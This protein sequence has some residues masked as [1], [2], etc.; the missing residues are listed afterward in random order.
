ML[1]VALLAMVLCSCWGGGEKVEP[2]NMG[3]LA[4]IDIGMTKDEV[5]SAI[6]E[7]H[8]EWKSGTKRD[9][10]YLYALPKLGERHPNCFTLLYADDVLTQIAIADSKG[11]LFYR[12]LQ[13]AGE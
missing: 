10:Y 9:A 12:P 2:L 13:P 7:R 5:V 4:K 3:D 11:R 8:F 1:A 6:G